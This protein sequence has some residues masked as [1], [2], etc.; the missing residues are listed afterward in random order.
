MAFEQIILGMF[1]LFWPFYFERSVGMCIPF[2]AFFWAGYQDGISFGMPRAM[3]VLANGLCGW[4]MCC[5]VLW[6][7][8]SLRQDLSFFYQ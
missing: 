8:K 4:L 3:M 7:Q 1:S 2:W 6:W 5:A